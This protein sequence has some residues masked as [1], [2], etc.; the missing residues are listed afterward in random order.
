MLG[1]AITAAAT[2][3]DAATHTAY[4]LQQ[5]IGDLEDELAEAD[6]AVSMA[7]QELIALREK[8]AAEVASGQGVLL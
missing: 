3:L 7:N 2:R 4:C 1:Q 5:D 6:A 8:R